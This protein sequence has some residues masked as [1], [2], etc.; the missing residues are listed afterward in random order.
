LQLADEP[1]DLAA[2]IGKVI[3]AVTP[4][5]EEKDLAIETRLRRRCDG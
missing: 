2:S 3:R 4:A 1:F 5:A